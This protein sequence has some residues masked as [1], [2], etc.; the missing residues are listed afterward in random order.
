MLRT[1]AIFIFA[2]LTAS[3]S[4]ASDLVTRAEANELR[5][6]RGSVVPRVE[7]DKD[8][9]VVSLRLNEMDLS[10]D[11]VRRIGQL[12]HLRRLVLFRTEFT[13]SDLAQLKGCRNLEHL[14]LTSTEVTDEGIDTILQLKKLRSL[15][16]GDVNISPEAVE[17][18]RE[19]NRSR[20]SRRDY[21][22]WGYSRR[23]NSP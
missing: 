9:S 7:R 18:L 19:L 10:D 8:G 4:H 11:D 21:L 16:I 13:D 12:R 22:R 3:S 2:V 14:N 20:A 15:C 17:R 23:T 6:S 5:L 1:S